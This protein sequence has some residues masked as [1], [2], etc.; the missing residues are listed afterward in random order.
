V[1]GTTKVVS[2]VPKDR[3]QGPFQAPCCN[4]AAGVCSSVPDAIPCPTNFDCILLF[5]A[6]FVC[7]DIFAT[8]NPPIRFDLSPSS[9]LLAEPCLQAG[10]TSR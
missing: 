6:I 4:T 7:F 5:G 9:P 1:V 10:V 8:R 3:E 2:K